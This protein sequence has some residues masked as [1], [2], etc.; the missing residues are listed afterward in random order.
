MVEFL[1]LTHA[2]IDELIAERL[3]RT[4]DDDLD[5]LVDELHRQWRALT[6]DPLRDTSRLLQRVQTVASTP[7]RGVPAEARVS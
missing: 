1:K 5:R 7:D 6:A 2:G 4:F 3:L